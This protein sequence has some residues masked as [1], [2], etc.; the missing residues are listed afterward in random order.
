MIY[1][2]QAQAF[3]Y[4]IKIGFTASNDITK[5]YCSL[6]C[7]SAVELN[8]LLTMSGDIRDEQKLHAQ[9]IN[10]RIRGEWFYPSEKLI[11][12][13]SKKLSSEK[14]CYLKKINTNEKIIQFDLD[15]FYNII[16]KN[17]LLLLTIEKLT[18]DNALYL[19]KETILKNKIKQ[20]YRKI[21]M[22]HR[23][24]L[25]IESFSKNCKQTQEK[26]INDIIESI[27]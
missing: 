27:K 18:K 22:L 1:F 13:L 4:L 7:S 2:I 25:Y 11:N 8:M 23:K 9:F 10:E 17:A 16:N 3:P 15:K 21:K 19:K 12:F 14:L 24:E 6:D 20:L 5:R 26:M